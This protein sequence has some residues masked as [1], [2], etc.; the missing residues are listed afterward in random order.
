MKDFQQNPQNNILQIILPYEKPEISNKTLEQIGD[1]F[2]N[3][4][5]QVLSSIIYK[6][7]GLEHTYILL[8]LLGHFYF[9]RVFNLQPNSK[10]TEVQG[11]R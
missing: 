11:L 7:Q 9:F 1:T 2:H 10:L 4:I 3:F 6:K 8:A 5:T